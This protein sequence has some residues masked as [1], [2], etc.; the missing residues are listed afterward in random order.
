MTK[1]QTATTTTTFETLLVNFCNE[2]RK[3][4]NSEKFTAVATDLATAVAF[5]GTSKMFRPTSQKR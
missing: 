3:D 4:S 2:Y 5:S 1:Q